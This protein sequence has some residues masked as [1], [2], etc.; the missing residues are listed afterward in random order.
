M[1]RIFITFL[2]VLLLFAF[3]M[4]AYAI[5]PAPFVYECGNTTFIF[6]EDSVFDESER[7]AI[8]QTLSDESQ[9]VEPCGLA[10]LFGHNYESE[11][12]VS[13]THRVSDTA[14]RCLEETFKIQMCTR[15]N[16]TITE[17]IG[18]RYISCCA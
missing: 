15:C 18:F 13:V 5:A 7:L 6:L 8:V 4:S 16:K 17:R 9:T 1:K 3:C 10:C 11:V 2:T 12:I 14:P